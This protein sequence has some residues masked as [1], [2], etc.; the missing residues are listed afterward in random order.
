LHEGRSEDAIK[1]FFN[2]VYELFVKVVMNP[3]YESNQKIALQSFDDRV[4]SAARKHL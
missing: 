4:R 3:F 1:N 2:E